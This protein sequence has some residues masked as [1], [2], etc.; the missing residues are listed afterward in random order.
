MKNNKVVNIKI[1]YDP[2]L[3]EDE[4]AINKKI[5]EFLEELNSLSAVTVRAKR[6]KVEIDYM[7]DEYGLE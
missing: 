4:V 6:Y 1:T 5:K 7:P 3:V 2:D